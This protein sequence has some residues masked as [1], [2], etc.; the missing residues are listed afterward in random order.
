MLIGFSM[1]SCLASSA[2][3]NEAC[4]PYHAF[5][6]SS[7]LRRRRSRPPTPPAPYVSGQSSLDAPPVRLKDACCG[8]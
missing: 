4:W 1:C 2:R 7:V 6:P 5:Y 8:R 3:S